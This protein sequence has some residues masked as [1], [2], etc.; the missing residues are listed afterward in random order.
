ML[1][2]IENSSRALIFSSF[3][4]HIQKKSSNFA[5]N[6]TSH[7]SHQNSAPGEV[8]EFIYGYEVQKEAHRHI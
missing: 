6:M 8:F 3:S 5:D 2:L 7:A 4:L 1:V